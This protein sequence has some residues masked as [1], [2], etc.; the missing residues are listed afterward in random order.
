VARLAHV[1][2]RMVLRCNGKQQDHPGGWG[3]ACQVVAYWQTRR[4]AYARRVTE[5]RSDTRWQGNAFDQRPVEG[6]NVAEGASSLYLPTQKMIV[7]DNK[8]GNSHSLRLRGHAADASPGRG[9]LG[10]PPDASVLAAAARWAGVVDSNVVIRCWD[11][12]Q[13]EPSGTPVVSIVGGGG[14]VAHRSGTTI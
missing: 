11:A 1:M 2:M 8:V 4:T 7:G 12:R 9:A 10:S 13:R 14:R 6:E 5:V 3:S